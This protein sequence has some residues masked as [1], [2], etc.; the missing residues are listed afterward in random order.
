MA[1]PPNTA[2]RGLR[3]VIEWRRH[4]RLT[5]PGGTV[6]SVPRGLSVLEASRA[7]GMSDSA[8]PV[9]AAGTRPLLDLPRRTGQGA[10]ALSP[11]SSPRS[12]ASWLGNGEDVRRWWHRGLAQLGAR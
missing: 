7:R 5:Y 4:V 10:A 6:V 8:G 12:G 11:P 1:G 2:A 9:C 3:G